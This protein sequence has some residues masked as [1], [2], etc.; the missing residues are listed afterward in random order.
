MPGMNGPELAKQVRLMCD[1]TNVKQP[2]ICCCSSNSEDFFQDNAF[3]HGVDQYLVKPV[4]CVDI[5]DAAMT[6]LKH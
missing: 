2:F 3:F 4:R 1:A 6:A 5:I